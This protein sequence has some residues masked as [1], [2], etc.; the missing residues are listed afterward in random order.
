[1]LKDF[2]SLVYHRGNSLHPRLIFSNAIQY[3]LV[4]QVCRTS[5]VVEVEFV[6]QV[7]FKLHSLLDCIDLDFKKISLF[8]T[9]ND[10]HFGG[11]IPSSLVNISDVCLQHFITY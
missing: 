10:I 2:G 5:T 4:C 1:M 9:P 11:H 6:V 3:F 8:I 7:S